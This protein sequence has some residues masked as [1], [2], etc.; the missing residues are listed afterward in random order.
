LLLAQSSDWPFIINNGT[1]TE[2]AERRVNDHVARFH[3]LA[4]ALEHNALDAERLTALEWLDNPFPNVDYRLF[5]SGE[6]A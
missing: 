2:Y 6:S 3:Y 4:D 1:A 5:Q